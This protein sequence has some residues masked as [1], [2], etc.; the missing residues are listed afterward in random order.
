MVLS[1]ASD[2]IEPNKTLG[3]ILFWPVFDPVVFL[4][5]F[6]GVKHGM[7]TTYSQ[8]RTAQPWIPSDH[9]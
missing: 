4:S 3:L 2:S 9:R 8:A 5:F 6:E 1:G 7:A